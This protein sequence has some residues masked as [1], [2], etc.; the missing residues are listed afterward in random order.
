[1]ILTLIKKWQSRSAYLKQLRKLREANPNCRIQNIHFDKVHLGEYCALL[2]G[3]SLQSV[4]LNRY[5]YISNGARLVNV[6]IGSFCSIGPHIHIGLGP[7]PSRNFVSTYPAFYSPSNTGCPQT[8]RQDRTFDESVPF[9]EIGNDVWIGSHVIIPGGITIGNGAIIAAGAVVVKNVPPYAIV[10]GN[11][12]KLIRYRFSEEE[13]SFLQKLC[14][15]EWPK[16][17]LMNHLNDFS[18]IRELKAK[19]EQQ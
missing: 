10:G 12:A 5:S 11:P 1:M 4:S 15:W 8:F 17:K 3:A 9:T 7:H 19:L 13:I 2:D 6:K 18:D 16:E 14:W